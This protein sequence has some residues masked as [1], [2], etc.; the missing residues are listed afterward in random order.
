MSIALVLTLGSFLLG[1]VFLGALVRPTWAPDRSVA[2]LQIRWGG[3]PS[4]FVEVAGMKVHLRDQGPG[5][6][7]PP[8]VLLHGTGSSLHTWDG[9]AEALQDEHRVIRFDLPGFGLTGPSP[10][11][12]YT[13]ESDVR[14]VIE[15]LDKLGIQRCVLGG[16]SDGGAVSWLTALEHPTRVHKLI[17][18]GAAGYPASSTPIRFRLVPWLMAIKPAPIIALLVRHVMP[19]GLVVRAF[20]YAFG[21]PRKVT[22]ILVD[23]SIELIQ[24]AGNRDALVKRFKQRKPETQWRR[25][26]ELKLP[27]L[28]I[29]GGLDRLMPLQDAERFHRE[30]AGSRFVIFGDLGHGP[31]EE[32]PRRSVIPVKDFLNT[33]CGDAS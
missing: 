4:I 7:A 24:R 8:I 14:F 19:R 2:E 3:S 21:D 25:I 32:D 6:E 20:R 22:P 16:N 17:L 28:I 18:V 27:T 10:D 5:G 13:L 11:G 1:L 23:R 12:V 31:Q 15:M 29:W 9:W 33:P 26:S 30:I